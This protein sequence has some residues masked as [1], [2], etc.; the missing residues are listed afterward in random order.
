V[1]HPSLP[2]MT[3]QVRRQDGLVQTSGR[4]CQRWKRSLVSSGLGKVTLQLSVL[5]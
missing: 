2:A 4:W 5:D 3:G 1:R